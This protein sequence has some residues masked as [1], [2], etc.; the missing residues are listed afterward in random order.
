MA[1]V[2]NHSQ[3]ATGVVPFSGTATAICAN[4]AS[5]V[6][7]YVKACY[8]HNNQASSSDLAVFVQGTGIQNRILNASLV[9]SETLEW[10]IAYN[11][12]LTGTQQLFATSSIPSGIN[13]FIYGARE[14]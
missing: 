13:Y 3:I 14:S 12:T 9:S 11:I 10:D 6:T 4:P 8:F 5:N 2:L 1:T 7:T